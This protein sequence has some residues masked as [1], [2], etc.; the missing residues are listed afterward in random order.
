VNLPMRDPIR[1]AFVIIF[2]AV[3]SS[4][5]IEG[6]IEVEEWFCGKN[7]AAF[8]G[9]CSAMAVNNRRNNVL[10]AIVVDCSFIFLTKC[11]FYSAV[12]LSIH[13][14]MVRC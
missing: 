7:E 3:L 8:S 10:S 2:I 11:G 14:W 13:H 5:A 6:Q 9:S 12:R 4:D 1:A